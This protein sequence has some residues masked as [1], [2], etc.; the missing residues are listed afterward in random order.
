M[1]SE[2]EKEL[3]RNEH[4]L[5]TFLNN[6]L[7]GGFAY[8]TNIF[9][10]DQI[11]NNFNATDHANFNTEHTNF[12]MDHTGEDANLT[13]GHLFLKYRELEF[14]IGR[15]EAALQ[16]EDSGFGRGGGKR[17][18]ISK[19]GYNGTSFEGALGLPPQ[20]QSSSSPSS[21]PT[22]TSINPI[23]TS[24]IL[25]M[26]NNNFQGSGSSIYSLPPSSASV[27]PSKVRRKEEIKVRNK[28]DCSELGCE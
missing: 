11:N 28:I 9:N 1:D 3:S 14:R 21:S 19:T 8:D 27:S 5:N 24:D 25:S 2:N 12:N 23:L 10:M 13:L 6:A 16:R 4:I 22:V 17:Q 20:T 18:R 26:N 15:I 7:K